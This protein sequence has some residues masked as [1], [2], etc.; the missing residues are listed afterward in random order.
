[1]H[2]HDAL[3]AAASGRVHGVLG[4][5][6]RCHHGPALLAACCVELDTDRA[7]R[8]AADLRERTGRF[9][10]FRAA[11]DDSLGGVKA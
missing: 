10:A 6:R 7:V 5:R 2:V 11:L 9:P 1:M 8:W 4:E 3:R